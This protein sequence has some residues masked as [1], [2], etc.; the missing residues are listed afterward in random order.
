MGPGRDRPEHSGPG[1]H[2]DPVRPGQ[3]VSRH[4][5]ES[6]GRTRLTL[7]RHL[8]QRVPRD[9]G[10]PPRRERLRLRQ[11]RPDDRQ[12]SRRQAHEALRR[13]RAPAAQHQ[14]DPVVQAVDRFSGR[15]VAPRTR[16]AHP[17][18]KTGARGHQP[19]GVHDASPSC[20]HGHRGDDARGRCPGRH[21]LPDPQSPGRYGRVP[22]RGSRHGIGGGPPQ[23]TPVH[24]TGAQTPTA[25]ELRPTHDPGVPDRQVPHDPGGGCRSHH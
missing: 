9:L 20:T 2:R 6:P 10:H 3:W 12:R 22:Q 7:P 14:R 16:V 25:L 5:W 15:R 19:H 24:R 23:V 11:N 1:P 8:H 17:S 21:Q 13:R 4:A 18:R